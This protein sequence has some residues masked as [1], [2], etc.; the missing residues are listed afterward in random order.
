MHR[1]RPS[2]QL[3]LPSIKLLCTTHWEYNSIM[4]PRSTDM[5]DNK[6]HRMRYFS[7][8]LN[9]TPWNTLNRHSSRNPRRDHHC[10]RCHHR[11]DLKCGILDMRQENTA[12]NRQSVFD[13][14]NNISKSRTRR[15]ELGT[16]VKSE[17]AWAWG[18]WGSVAVWKRCESAGSMGVSLRLGKDAEEQ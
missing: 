15:N 14:P 10:Y 8:K 7:A 6:A 9:F 3:L 11:P 12:Q 17:S 18:R 5:L 16:E 2:R 13:T 1:C 4:L